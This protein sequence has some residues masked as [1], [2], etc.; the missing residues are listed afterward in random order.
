MG[1]A[2]DTIVGAA[3]L[4]SAAPTL[5]NLTMASGDTLT[6]RSFASPATALLEQ[7]FGN[8]A[9]A[10]EFSIRS[11]FFYDNIRGYQSWNNDLPMVRGIPRLPLQ[12]LQSQD[13]L[14]AQVDGTAS[15]VVLLAL[16]IYYSDVAGQAQNLAM[17]GDIAGRIQHVYSQL[18]TIDANIAAGEWGDFPLNHTVDQ[19]KGNT[20]HAILGFLADSEVDVIAVKGQF[21]GSL[22]IGAPGTLRSEVSV[23]YFKKLSDDFGTPH[24]PIVNAADKG[25]TFVSV[26]HHAANPTP[27]IQLI[28]AELA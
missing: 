8:A 14:T 12:Y 9:H 28:M 18:V 24:I 27:N 4:A 2:I 25:N 26:A 16:Q 13:V 10:F 6:V 21:S 19:M 7:V 3:T 20:N 23:D 5:T 17:W 15:D 11:P 1:I 22:R